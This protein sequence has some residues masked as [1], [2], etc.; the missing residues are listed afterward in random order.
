MPSLKI[1]FLDVGHGDFIYATT[2]LGDNLVIDV[3][4]GGVVPSQFLSNVNVISELQISHPHTDHFDDIISMSRKTIKSFRCPSVAKFEDKTIGWKKSDNSK[5]AK[6]RQMKN[7]LSAD[8][9]AVAVGDGFGHSVWFPKNIDYNDPNTASAVTTLSYKGVKV[10]FGGDLPESGWKSLLENQKFVSA[11]S[12]TTI[13][14]VPHHG[15]K[16]GCS[17]ALFEKISP[18]LCII[19]DKSLD[20]DNKNTVA[21]NW[22]STRTSGCNVVGGTEK[23]KVLSTRSDNSIFIKINENGE[24]WVHT[25]TQWKKD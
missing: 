14:K 10:L 22:Y 21:T 12:G 3:G 23:R 18:M 7:N 5:I 6:L 1:S 20:K 24:F 11:I 4:S 2:P 17:E 19:S 16:E 8:D 15:R 9:T 13:L 25:N